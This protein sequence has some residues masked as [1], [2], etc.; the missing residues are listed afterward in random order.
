[1]PEAPSG[2][3]DSWAEHMELMFDLQVLAL[4]ADITRVISMK[5]GLDLSNRTFPTSGINKSHHAASHHGGHEANILDF[6]RINTYR[7]GVVSHFLEKLKNTM[8][9]ATRT[10]STRRRSFGDRPWVTR[11]STTIGAA[12]SS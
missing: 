1:M 2:V 7:L 4:E 12:H 3:P 11:T 8:G 6:H 10:C 5:T 9:R